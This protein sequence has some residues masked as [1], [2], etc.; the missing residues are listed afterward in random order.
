M[1]RAQAGDGGA[2]TE[3]AIKPPR[4]CFWGSPCS[5]VKDSSAGRLSSV[6]EGLRIWNALAARAEFPGGSAK[7]RDRFVPIYGWPVS[8]RGAS[9]RRFL[10]NP[11]VYGLRDL[12]PGGGHSHAVRSRQ[13]FRV[14][15]GTERSEGDSGCVQGRSERDLD[16]SR[17]AL[18]WP[19]SQVQA[20]SLAAPGL[21]VLAGA[22]Q[23]G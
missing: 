6:G 8:R 19:S 5:Y 18:E 12:L 23:C 10:A 11:R 20:D 3:L 9:C 2:W 21:M 1:T 13:V 4:S 16:R 17:R 14:V 7:H 22:C 15:P